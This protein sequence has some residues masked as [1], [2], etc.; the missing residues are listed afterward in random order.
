[1][2][3][4]N[5]WLP[6]T[7]ALLC[8]LH[9]WLYAHMPEAHRNWGWP[10]IVMHNWHEQGFWHLGGKLVSN[11]GGLDVGETPLVYPGHRPGFLILPY[12]L[13][14]LPGAAEATGCYMTL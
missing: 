10:S 4:R 9:L 8:C 5:A 1:M 3:K 6:G 12:W 11:A 7:F 14:E 2:F 13:K